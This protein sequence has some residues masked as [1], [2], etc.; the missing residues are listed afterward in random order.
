MQ[1]ISD[2]PI[3][4]EP[5]LHSLLQSDETI[6]Y[7]LLR[8]IGVKDKETELKL[9]LGRNDEDKVTDMGKFTDE[10]VS[11]LHRE[12]LKTPKH[13]TFGLGYV[14]LE[15]SHH[16][17]Y[18]KSNLTVLNKSHDKKLTI[19]GQAFGVGAFEEEDLDIYVKDDMSNYD[20]E[21]IPE[22]STKQVDVN[23]KKH[24]LYDNFIMSS[25]L[26]VMEQYLPPSIPASF[27][28]KYRV[29]RSR[30]EPITNEASD[31]MTRKQVNAETRHKILGDI[32]VTLD[33]ATQ[34]SS[35]NITPEHAG[36][37]KDNSTNKPS[38]NNFKSIDFVNKGNEEVK[39][40]TETKDT[41]SLIES[42]LI[43]DRFVSEGANEEPIDYGTREMQDAAKMKMFG[44][45][46]RVTLS[47]QPV[48]LLCK[49]F[50]LPEP[51][52]G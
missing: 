30:F 7:I 32:S 23:A 20:F 39:E 19:T 43:F 2:G 49:R 35:S 3:P 52:Y 45:L 29:K 28:G 48:S 38:N 22:K 27:S 47:W 16:P 33:S 9:S 34:S 50:N 5:V 44:P 15:K 51:L 11:E 37:V 10:E 31:V 18:S 25:E 17:I 42:S 12:Y 36:I 24:L 4:G 1:I 13:N 8:N 6:G 14:G 41:S 21:L 40:S 26:I 46:T